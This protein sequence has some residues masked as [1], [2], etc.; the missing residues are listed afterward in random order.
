M[1]PVKI[2]SATEVGVFKFFRKRKPVPAVPPRTPPGAAPALYVQ[3]TTSSYERVFNRVMATVVGISE[4]E[5]SEILAM[6]NRSGS[7]G[8]NMAGYFEQVYAAYF[9]G[10]DWT[11]T[12]YDQ[13]ARIFAE[14]GAYP[15][16]WTDI[17]QPAKPC[18][19]TE[20]LLAQR[21]GDIRAFLDGRGVEY[22]PHAAKAQLVALA[23]VTPGLE[24]STLWQAVLATRRQDAQ[25]AAERRPRLLYDLLI[26]TIAYRAKSERDAE[27]AKAAG[28]KRFD[29]MLTIEADRPF[30]EVARKKSPSAVP[31]FFPNDFTLLRPIIE[32]GE[33]GGR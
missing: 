26:R 30:V 7:D 4:E 28:V 32:N 2:A 18:T 12:E 17:D 11:W 16:H 27:R 24:D 29:L 5:A 13:W 31:P 6:V 10:R 15:S 9:R 33:P 23:E 8:L 19:R 3:D 21:V 25:A 22:P 1:S 14:M 20:E